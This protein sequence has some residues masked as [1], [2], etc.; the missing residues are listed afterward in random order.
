MTLF[1]RQYF[2]LGKFWRWN[3]E[4]QFG[5]IGPSDA[6]D[7]RGSNLRKGGLR[8]PSWQLMNLGVKPSPGLCWWVVGE[9]AFF[10]G[11]YPRDGAEIW[12]LRK[13]VLGN[14]EYPA[15]LNLCKRNL[16]RT[17]R[18]KRLSDRKGKKTGVRFKGPKSP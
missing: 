12:L 4:S 18:G 10:F 3:R 16:E 14:S 11:L 9:L 2:H 6:A 8:K 13:R 7:H 5:M 17:E 15:L 1:P